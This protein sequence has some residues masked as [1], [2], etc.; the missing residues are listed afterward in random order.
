MTGSKPGSA[1]GI[2][3]GWQEE[4][5]QQKDDST[6]LNDIEKETV[7]E[8]TCGDYGDDIRVV[9]PKFFWY[10]LFHKTGSE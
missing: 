4:K 9:L 10:R 6:V 1:H 3:S 5:K 7:E 2:Q 8:V